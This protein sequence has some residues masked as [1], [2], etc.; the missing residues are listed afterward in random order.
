MLKNRVYIKTRFFSPATAGSFVLFQSI[1][2]AVQLEF[3]ATPL[4][5]AA[6]KLVEVAAILV[7][8]GRRFHGFIGVGST[9]FSSASRSASR[10][11]A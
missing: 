3:G 6:R 7:T 10:N 1:V 9:H 4:W 11:E 5:W 8:P 2:F